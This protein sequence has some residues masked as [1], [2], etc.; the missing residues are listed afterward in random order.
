M[1]T[2]FMLTLLVACSGGTNP[3]RYD[4]AGTDQGATLDAGA[5]FGG[6]DIGIDPTD[7]GFDAGRDAG[8]DAYVP[9]TAMTCTYRSSTYGSSMIEIDTGPGSSERL[10]FD[11]AAMPD[12]S[13]IDSATLRFDSYDA[14]H[15]GEE[16]TIM[17]NGLGPLDLP[18]MTAWDN[19]MGTG[20]VNV[21]AQLVAGDNL[22]EFGP[23]PL[24]RSLFRIGNV[25]IIAEA[26]VGE[27]V[28]APPPPPPD[29]VERRMH[30][31]EAT[32]GNRPT[33]VVPCPPGHPRY[34]GSRNY[35]FTA[36]GTEHD[37]TD[38]DGGFVPGGNRLGTATFRF[39]D[40]IA[41]RYRVVIRSRH[42]ENRNPAGALFIVDGV[43]RRIDQ[44]TS[45]DY[46]DDVW[47]ERTLDGTVDVVLDS[48]REGNS[49]SVT[50]VRLE[51]I[52]G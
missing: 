3:M 11:V 30:F 37:P 9:P 7:S 29:A 16:G 32:Y 44:T 48:S 4:D 20:A 23:G 26:R 35:A 15:P 46:E 51:P 38:C 40:V 43:E 28:S 41:A 21:T 50:E 24:S 49:D 36:R 47:G 22:I 27:C 19:A 14:D 31:S 8:A 34:N 1:R 13:L 39:E 5:D 12:P 17:V 6:P 10:V 52:A 18:A 42:T 45:S 25:E 2:F 33:W